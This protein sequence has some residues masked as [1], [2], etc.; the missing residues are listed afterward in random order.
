MSK[1]LYKL[2]AIKF[3]VFIVNCGHTTVKYNNVIFELPYTYGYQYS[4][5]IN[6]IPITINGITSKDELFNEIFKLVSSCNKEYNI[7]YI[8]SITTL[9]NK[10]LLLFL[11]IPIYTISFNKLYNRVGKFKQFKLIYS[12]DEWDN[13]KKIKEF[14]EQILK[15]I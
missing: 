9:D 4:K 1:E 8:Y 14:N 2:D 12:F 15:N 5:D 3:N 10:Q 6:D 7:S 13:M 11:S